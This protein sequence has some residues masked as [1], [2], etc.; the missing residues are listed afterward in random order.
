MRRLLTALP[1]VAV[2][3]AGG[4]YWQS[5]PQLLSDTVTAGLE[6]NAAHGRLVF[7]AGGCASCHAAEKASGD[8]ELVLSGGQA[9]PSPYG[10]FRVP[11]I[12]SDATH[13]IGSWTLTE[14][15]SAMTRGV[16]PGPRGKAPRH[17]YPAFPYA[18]YAHM[19]LQDIADL[20]AYLQTLPADPSPS[21][22][23]ELGFPFD[24][25]RLLAGWKWL[26][27]D[28]GWVVTGE[29]TPEETRGR[30]LVEGMG[31]CAECHTPRDALGGLERDRWLA[32]VPEGSPGA[33]QQGDVPD[34]SPGGLDWSEDEIVEYLTSGFTPD[35]DSAGGHMAL[36]VGNFARLPE[37]DRHAVAAYLKRV[38]ASAP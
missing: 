1:V 23:H 4:A 2:L 28:R 26:Y 32:G 10:T 37:A 8:A 21:L 9:I 29:L 25:R 36:V 11:N 31:H 15:A 33:Q 20:F 6:G 17:L 12:S 14:F 30:Y 27:L 3:L 35:Y 7:L 22:P 19:G 38:P 34:I 5:R 24:Q 18:S 13:G 16:A